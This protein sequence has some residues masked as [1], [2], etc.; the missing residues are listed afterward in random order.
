[1]T[2]QKAYSASRLVSC[3]C[4]GLLMMSFFGCNTEEEPLP[5]FLE[6]KA[7]KLQST[8]PFWHG[9]VSEK[10]TNAK[11]FAVNKISGLSEPLGVLSLPASVPVLLDGDYELQIFP[12]I[13]ANGNSLYLDIYPFYNRY[14]VN[15]AFTPLK[16]TVVNP[17]TSYLK[18]SVFALIEDLEG[19]S[20]LF[21]ED[22]DE[23]PKTKIQISGDEVFEGKFSGKVE[24]DTANSFFAVATKN[25]YK[26]TVAT[27]GKF[28]IEMNYKTD[29]PLE[30]GLLAVD[31]TGLETPN[32]EFV[33][34]PK[35]EW[36]KIYFKLTELI[37]TAKTDKFYFAIRGAIPRTDGKYSLQNANVFFDNIKVIHF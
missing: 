31:A 21:S 4:I 37:S 26:L 15:V 32:F 24:L 18:E 14:N 22:R 33:V 16:T 6:V 11:V 23:N 19:Q 28:Y 20:Q 12:I 5:A 35:K 34:L 36:N 30:I 10:I 2:F 17:T 27:G 25:Q 13:K 8:N 3:F 1:M 29:V 7:F 9:S